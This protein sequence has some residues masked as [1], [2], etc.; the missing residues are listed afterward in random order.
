MHSCPSLLVEEDTNVFNVELPE[1]L[2][3]IIEKTGLLSPSGIDHDLAD[4]LLYVG[5]QRA[6]A[7]MVFVVT[8][9]GVDGD[10]VM[11][12]ASL[13]ATWHVVVDGG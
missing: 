10:E 6:G 5:R 1:I 7:V 3:D 9:A 4:V 8:L 12:D 11:L 2:L 13:D